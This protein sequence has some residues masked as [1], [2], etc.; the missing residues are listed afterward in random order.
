MNNAQT[1]KS[2]DR[3]IAL[4]DGI[5][6]IAMTLLVLDVRVEPG[7]DSA[8][9]HDAVRGVLPDLGAY[10]LSF[11][12]LAGFWRDHRR[13]TPLVHRTGRLSVL[14]ELVWLCAI[15]LLP[16]PTSL[17]SEYASQ[18]LAVT[19]Y[20]GAVTI[21]NLL[22]LAW[23]HAG[24]SGPRGAGR[25]DP[26]AERV[27]RSVTAD[28]SATALVFGVSIVLAYTASAPTALW[29]WLA[30]FPIRFVLGRRSRAARPKPSP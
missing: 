5:F 18:P 10:G 15:A 13:L 29:S 4:S 3:L 2:A 30:L 6:A 27:V 17:L 28:L 25:T 9:F 1:D 8:G 14:L 24:R 23:L 12:I 21:T 7:L 22:E 11:M 26:D 20:A 16:F 19:I